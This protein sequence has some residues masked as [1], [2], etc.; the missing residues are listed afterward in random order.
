MEGWVP[1]WFVHGCSQ[2]DRSLLHVNDVEAQVLK[3]AGYIF[4]WACMGKGEGL[5]TFIVFIEIYG[6]SK[7]MEIIFST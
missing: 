1:R 6:T 7:I 5:F 4:C 2:S 3:A